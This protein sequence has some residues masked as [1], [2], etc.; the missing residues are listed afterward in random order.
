MRFVFRPFCGGDC[1]GHEQGGLAV[2]CSSVLGLVCIDVDG[3]LV[4]PSHEPTDAVWRATAAAVARGQHL[5][6]STG[7]GAFGPTIGFARRLDPD[8][9]HIFHNGAALVHSSTGEQQVQPLDGAVV[10]F[11]GGVAE[12]NGW[13]IEYYSADDYTV[14]SFTDL[15]VGHAQL[16]GVAHVVRPIDDLVDPIVRLQFVVPIEVL[17]WV[18]TEMTGQP[19][20]VVHAT[21]PGMPGI[22]FVSCTS[23]G[24]SKGQAIVDLA[25]KLSLDVASVMM[26]GDGLNDLEAIKTAGHG[27]AMGNA[28]AEV[29]AVADHVVGNVDQDGLVEALDLAACL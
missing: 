23:P 4:G 12:R 3:T 11:C 20:E 14:D 18:M 25:G 15:A 16:L 5:A 22:A 17:P 29:K 24:V 13:V 8:G 7:R 6:L 10:E 21:A 9:W 19:A 26:V 27:V 1:V 28:A 2:P